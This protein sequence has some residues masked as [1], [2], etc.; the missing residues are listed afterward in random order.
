MAAGPVTRAAHHA[1]VPSPKQARCHTVFIVGSY[2][3]HFAPEIDR[4]TDSAQ[5]KRRT[6]VKGLAASSLIPL[7]GSNLVGCSD[8]SDGDLF[9]SVPAEF[10]HGVASGD[11]LTDRVILWTRV[12]PES[13]GRVRVGWEVSDDAGFANVVASGSGATDAEV[14]Y[15]LKVDVTGLA[16]GATYYYRFTTGNRLSPVG[17]TRTLPAGAVAAASFAVVS[18]SNYPAGYFNVYREIAA[19]DVDAVLHL[20]DYLYEYAPGG[21]AS[22]RAEEFGRVVEPANELLSLADY[23]TRYAQYRGDEDL[24]A[25]HGAHPFFIVWDDHEIANDAWREGAENHDPSEG[26]F[27]ERK[28]AAI[29]AWYEW[30]PVRPPAEIDEIIYRRFRY[31]DL[32]DLL[33]LDT[34]IIGRDE[35]NSY[36]EFVSGGMI[37]VAAARASF[38]AGDR[39]LLGDDQR[40]WLRE[41]LSGSSARWQVLGQQVL[42]GRYH[43]PAP[44]LEALDPA[45]AGPDAIEQ[46]TE[47]VLEAVTAK[48]TPEAQR[49]P[50]QQALL[51]S[52]IPYNLDAWD[53]YEF[54]RDSL[55]SFAIDVGSKLVVL[56]GD[57]H[58][59]WSSQ[60]TTPDGR[61]AGV[62]FGCASV[63]SPGFEGVLGAGPAAL[64][65]PLVT[66]LIDDLKYADLSGRG[67]PALRPRRGGRQP[68]LRHG[69]RHPQLRDRYGEDH[70]QFGQP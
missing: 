20:G 49:T 32:L 64:F 26:S 51:D 6:L 63:T 54:E 52:A 30:Q 2:T 57:T 12:T 34:R 8:G 68:P 13:A 38:G 40:S 25:C 17:R 15:T 44:I 33:M 41:Q 69:H 28:L 27:A 14:D 22:D 3:V 46:G 70:R 11:P 9:D 42:S 1:T 24:Q 7:L 5:L 48:N 29:Q 47:A 37:D 67:L 45:I 56:A 35:Q 4:M 65:T 19:Q 58:N 31:G 59:A 16:P 50:E 18:C 61:I 53:G 36:S 43:L 39:S 21:Y 10:R 55:L 60:L 66:T 62:E 23:R